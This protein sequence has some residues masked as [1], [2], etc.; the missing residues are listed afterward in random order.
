MNREEW[1]ASKWLYL[2][3][4]AF[5]AGI[6]VLCIIVLAI[7]E[8]PFFAIGVLLI[9]PFLFWLIIVPLLHWKDRYIG[10]KSNLWGVLILVETT[11]WFKI[12]YWFRHIIPDW[13]QNGRY[14]NAE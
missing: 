10:E 9:V 7:T 8:I 5:I 2:K 3:R 6:G 12:I 1:F 4:F 14:S 11:G 13:K